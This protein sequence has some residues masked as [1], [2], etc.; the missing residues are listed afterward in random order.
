MRYTH[1]MDDFDK[2]VRRSALKLVAVGFLI[3]LLVGF[4]VGVSQAD[5]VVVIPLLQGMS[6]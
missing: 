6:N 4:L 1:R 3:G 2:Q 5:R